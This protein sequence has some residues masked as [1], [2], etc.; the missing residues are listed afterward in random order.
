MLS[1]QIF[2]RHTVKTFHNEIV[3]PQGVFGIATNLELSIIVAMGVQLCLVH[4]AHKPRV[5][6]AVYSVEAHMTSQ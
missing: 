2:I 4:L 3:Y 5:L 6:I 1:L